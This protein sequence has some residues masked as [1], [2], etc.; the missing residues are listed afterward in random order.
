MVN[1]TVLD[2]YNA[3]QWSNATAANTTLIHG[4]DARGD[5]EW[6]S[7]GVSTEADMA[8]TICYIIIGTVGII[9][10]SLSFLSQTVLALPLHETT[11]KLII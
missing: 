1:T 8:L 2:E 7:G 6:K 11:F 10:K 5:G 3:T 9:G 4:V